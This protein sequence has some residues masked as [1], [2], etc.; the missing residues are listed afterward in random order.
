M[1]NQANRSIRRTGGLPLRTKV[2]FITW[3][4][5]RDLV[6]ERAPAPSPVIT[7]VAGRRSAVPQSAEDSSAPTYHNVLAR[8]S[9]G[10][11]TFMPAMMSHR[12]FGVRGRTMRRV[13]VLS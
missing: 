13:D 10:Q 2:Q 11:L 12:F 9:D 8:T 7:P 4:E 5:Q 3:T 1:S 6:G